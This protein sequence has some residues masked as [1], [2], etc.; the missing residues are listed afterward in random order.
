MPLGSVAAMNESLD[1]D[2]DG[3]DIEVALYVGNP[4]AGGVEINSTDCPGYTRYESV[5][6]ER[7]AAA[8][9][10]KRLCVAEFTA[11]AAWDDEPDYCQVFIGADAWDFMPLDDF[12]VP[13]AG[14]VEK[15]V[16]VFHA[17]AT[18]E[19]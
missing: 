19:A 17:D 16:D 7:E 14:T 6:G 5:S 10:V 4:A 1:N 12:S 15:P 13:G 3:V 8:G 18:E 11:S 9:G 2:Y